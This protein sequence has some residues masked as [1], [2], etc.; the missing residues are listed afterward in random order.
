MLHTAVQR[1]SC[2]SVPL[3]S[4]KRPLQAYIHKSTDSLRLPRFRHASHIHSHIRT[5]FLARAT[6]SNGFGCR[7]RFPAPA[8]QNDAR[9]RTWSH[10]SPRRPRETHAACTI[11]HDSHTKRTLSNVKMHESP[12][13]PS[14]SN[15][16][17][18]PKGVPRLPRDMH[19]HH[20]LD[21]RII[22][23]SPHLPGETSTHTRAATRSRRTELQRPIA[24]PKRTRRERSRTL[25]NARWQSGTLGGH[26]KQH[27]DS[28]KWAS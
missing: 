20:P 12:H 14:E 21:T 24:A 11:P 4:A 10:H 26:P 6:K 1:A 5:R 19:V 28:G 8:T 15:A 18:P 3:R 27:L 13:L 9:R 17:R 16:Q 2:L 23:D 22:H 25:A 7:A